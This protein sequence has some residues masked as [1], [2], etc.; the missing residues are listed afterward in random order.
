MTW[1]RDDEVF[2]TVVSKELESRVFT[3]IDRWHE[4]S[5]YRAPALGEHCRVSNMRERPHLNGLEAEI[6]SRGVDDRGYL[7]VRIYHD[8][9]DEGALARGRRA[10]RKMKVHPS[11]LAPARPN[12]A[13]PTFPN[14]MLGST[15]RGD[16]GSAVSLA[17]TFAVSRSSRALGSS[18][19]VSGLR[20]LSS[21]TS[22]VSASLPRSV[23]SSELA[24]R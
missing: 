4:S 6:V 8:I 7:T 3:D 23:S 24:R 10:G 15:M 9:A 20:S 13:G 18:L 17:T 22:S 16:T 12:D 1:L 14:V 19:S 5:F 21:P 2:K 11:R